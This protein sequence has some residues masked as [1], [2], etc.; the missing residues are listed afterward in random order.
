MGDVLS[1]KDSRSAPRGKG[2]V[3]SVGTE[4]GDG[5]GYVRFQPSLLK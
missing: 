3:G 1:D 4:V 2:S 5:E